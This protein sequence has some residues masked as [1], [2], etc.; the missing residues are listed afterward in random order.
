MWITQF[1]LQTHHTCR[2]LV[3]F[4]RGR[5]CCVY[6]SNSS[7]LI[8]AYYLLIM[9]LHSKVIYCV[10]KKWPPYSLSQYFPPHLKY[11]A[12]LLVGIQKFKF[13]VKLPNKIKT[14]IILFCKKWK[15]HS[16]SWI[17]IVIITTV[18]Q[19]VQRLLAHN[20]KT[21]KR[22]LI[23]AL[24]MMLWFIPCQTCSKRSYYLLLFF[25]SWTPIIKMVNSKL[26]RSFIFR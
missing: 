15:F 22:P 26:A 11:V 18:V 17:N 10:R 19:F 2:H 4:T 3:A 24:S 8:A 25:T 21:H 16:Y 1:Y 7:H 9:V 14:R 12:A 23:I 20:A 13:V 5:H 6:C